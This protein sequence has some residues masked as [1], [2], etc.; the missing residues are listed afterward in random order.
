MRNELFDEGGGPATSAFSAS[1]AR[2]TSCRASPPDVGGGAVLHHQHA[3]GSFSAS[4][5]SSSAILVA[6][7]AI[8][9]ELAGLLGAVP[10]ARGT[11]HRQHRQD[12]CAT[13][14]RTSQQ[15]MGEHGD[16][17]LDESLSGVKVIKGYNA[18]DYIQ[19]EVLRPERRVL[20]R[21]TPLDGA[22]PAAGF[23]DE[24]VPGDLGRGR[25]PRLRR[26]RSSFKGSLSAGELRGLRR[27]V[28]ADH[29]PRAHRSSTSSPTSTRASRPAS[30]SSR[31]STPRAK[32]R[33]SPARWS[34]TA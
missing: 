31:S 3:A 22:P 9:W 28:L 2:A 23:A 4:R 25:D 30:A 26:Y 5:S 19:P 10:A 17:S 15:G 24:R 13:R 6:M 16:R 11:H 20:A 12:A 1:S 14:P 32:F 33:T 8:S 29:A 7:V 21:L 34:R 27:H 18:A